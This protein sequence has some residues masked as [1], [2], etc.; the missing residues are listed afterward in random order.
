MRV[1]VLISA[2]FILAHRSN[3]PFQP[4]VSATWAQFGVNF[5]QQDANLGPTSIHLVWVQHGATWPQLG[6][7]WAQLRPKLGPT[8]LQNGGH[9]GPNPKSSKCAFA[10]VSHV[11][12]PLAQL[13]AKLSPNGPKLRH[14]E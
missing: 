14:V 3:S 1:T 7:V 12:S 6:P 10:M 9:G 4:R 2:I 11:V 8:G 5:G 13:V